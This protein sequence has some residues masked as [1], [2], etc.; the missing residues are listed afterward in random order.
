MYGANNL[1]WPGVQNATTG[2]VYTKQYGFSTLDIAGAY[3]G[4][5]IGSIIGQVTSIACIGN[6]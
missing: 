2:T 5:L 3:T 4:A 6:Y 1:V